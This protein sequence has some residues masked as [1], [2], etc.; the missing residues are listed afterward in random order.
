MW[1]KIFMLSP[2]YRIIVTFT[3]KSGKEVKVRCDHCKI[4]YN[5]N[6]LTGYSLDGANNADSLY[7]R[8]TEIA[9]IQWKSN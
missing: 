5:G 9:A 1:N 3:M 8:I 2:R 4:T 7:I 6:E